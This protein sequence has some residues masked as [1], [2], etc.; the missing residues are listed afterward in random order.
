VEETLLKMQAD[1]DYKA[2]TKETEV[3][4]PIARVDIAKWTKFWE[5]LTTISVVQRRRQIRLFPTLS[6]SMGK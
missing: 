6:V 4:K 3:E 5:F 1:D 2:A